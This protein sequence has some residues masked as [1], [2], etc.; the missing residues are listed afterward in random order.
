M[1]RGLDIGGGQCAVLEPRQAEE[2]IHMR[3]V[4]VIQHW[5]SEP[6]RGEKGSL[7]WREQQ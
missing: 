3:A 4:A 6:R 1:K 5:V 2:G 7:L